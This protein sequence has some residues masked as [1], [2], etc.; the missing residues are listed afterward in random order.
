MKFIINMLVLL[1]LIYPDIKKINLNEYEFMELTQLPLT[2]TQ[3]TDLDLYLQQNDIEN[4][5]DLLFI[6]SISNEDIHKLKTFVKL[7]IKNKNNFFHNISLDYLSGSNNNNM[8]NNE[9]I[10]L[11]LQK[12]NINTMSY[13]DLSIIPS[14]S[15]VDVSAVLKQQNKGPIK[16][17]F[18]LKN[19]PG[20]SNYAYKK[21]LKYVSFTNESVNNDNIHLLINASMGNEQSLGLEDEEQ[22]AIYIGGN[23][24]ETTYSL[25]L[26]YKGL[27][28]GHL[29]HN[30]FGDP[31]G[32]YTNK[33]FMMYENNNIKENHFK[34]IVGNF[35]AS[36]GKGLVFGSG[37]YN[38]SRNTG[39]K[40][41]K[42]LNGIY[43]DM[44]NSH[45]L[46]LNGLAV[47]SS[48]IDSGIYFSMFISEDK[49]DAVINDG[50]S[51][52]TNKN[53]C[54]VYIG[55]TWESS[56]EYCY[57]N[58]NVDEN[59]DRSFTSLIFMRPRLG[60]GINDNNNKIIENMI[61]AVT[62]RTYGLD[63]SFLINE[64]T[65]FGLTYYQ[66]L[67]DRVLDPQI[68]YTIVGGDEDETPV[69]ES[70]DY[71]QYSGDAYY[72]NYPQGNSTDAEL[73]AMYSSSITSH[74]NWSKARSSRTIRGINF[75]KIYNNIVFQFEFSDLMMENKENP[76]AYLLN[77]YMTFKNFDILIL[78]RDYDLEY[79]NPYQKSFS[80]YARYKS[81]ILE[82]IWWLENPIY[83]NLYSGAIVPQAEK[84]TY[85]ESW[86][87]FHRNFTLGLEWDSW[88]RKADNAK[89][90]RL[91]TKL[92]WR[93]V[94]NY[95][96]KF[97]YKLQGRGQFSLQH[98]SPYLINEARV[99]F[100]LRLS[101]YNK[102]ALLYSW[103]NA[104]F[105]P[106]PRL[107]G[108]SSPNQNV[109]SIG[110]PDESIGVKLK[111]SFNKN[112]T[113]EA[114]AVYA[115]GFLWYF[116][117]T[118]FKIFND[119][120]GLTNLW[121][122]FNVKPI[123]TISIDMKASYTIDSPATNIDGKLVSGQ[124][125]DN[126]YILDNQKFNYRIQISYAY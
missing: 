4:I 21:M 27:R 102:L 46:T 126:T 72:L 14:V 107:M 110:S 61:D 54:E 118:T 43:P 101:D 109:G 69:F 47:E 31:N 79:D 108:D 77:T 65:N 115:H 57:E 97:A 37:D 33:T 103:N 28:F 55:C 93:P 48:F 120:F 19:S 89:Y 32:V 66:S 84:G 125:F 90:F 50:C 80:Q 99:D 78:H 18:H 44:T 12:K 1:A 75:E 13:R 59:I 98:P 51:G 20:L 35:N 6:Q 5:Y 9:V 71:D 123:S 82:D 56:I 121:F 2:S 70:N 88:M 16:E 73:A 7:D 11:Y 49:R 87:R 62:E 105:G 112:L 52:F 15:P 113:L 60:L 117:S 34:V 116:D 36:F 76:Q 106:R 122:S 22:D 42:R 3:I 10:N 96:I 25:S 100:E 29:R 86:Y 39:Y 17:S 8:L 38:R 104:T 67:Y 26:G 85:I 45:Q 53:Q 23:N 114:G 74:N 94:F 41:R 111:H 124:S 40:Y 95:R 58:D 63:F 81:S 83:Y 92:E 24:P 30:N 119:D 91:K 68:E 64:T